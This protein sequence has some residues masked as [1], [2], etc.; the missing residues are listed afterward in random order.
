MPFQIDH[1]IPLKHGGNSEAENL[2]LSCYY[3]NSRKGPNLAGIDPA[4]NS[5]VPLFHPRQQ[6]W[7]EH[8]SWSGPLLRGNTPAGRATIAV[9]CI[10]D[11]DRVAHRRDAT[12]LGV[13]F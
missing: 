9:M 7:S 13:R 12:Q 11:P 4:S 6:E 3:C 8:F 2:A 10:N 5:I 1:I